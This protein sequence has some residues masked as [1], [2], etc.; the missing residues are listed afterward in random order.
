M[1][2]RF[3]IIFTVT[4]AALLVSSIAYASKKKL[5]PTSDRLKQGVSEIDLAANLLD[6]GG[7]LQQKNQKESLTRKSGY[8]PLKDL[9]IMGESVPPDKAAGR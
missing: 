3:S 6:T 4:A 9:T 1:K 2:K 8:E 5:R 7:A